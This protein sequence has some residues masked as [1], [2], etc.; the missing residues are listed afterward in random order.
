[1]KVASRP[2][3]TVTFSNGNTKSGSNAKTEVK[4]D[5]N[6]SCYHVFVVTLLL[7]IKMENSQNKSKWF[8]HHFFVTRITCLAYIIRRNCE[9]GWRK[10]EEKLIW[11]PRLCFHSSC[12]VS[13]IFSRK[14]FKRWKLNNKR[15]TWK[16]N[17][18]MKSS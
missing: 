1:M 10:R 17:L 8:Y 14:R 18:S 3:A 7:Y 11:L 13:S 9:L 12:C 16:W 6:L 4:I 5:E 2:W 15:E